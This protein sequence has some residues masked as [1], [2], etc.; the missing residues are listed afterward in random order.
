M[1][2]IITHPVTGEQMEYRRVFEIQVRLM[3]RCFREK[4]T[5]YTPFRVR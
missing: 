4:R 5:D 3:A 1:S 2:T